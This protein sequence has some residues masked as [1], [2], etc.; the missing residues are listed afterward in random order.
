M[1]TTTVEKKNEACALSSFRCV[2]KKSNFVSGPELLK[3]NFN[4][5]QDL[6][7]FPPH[8]LGEDSSHRS[9]QISN[10]GDPY[11]PSRDSYLRPQSE[12]D[13]NYL[14]PEPPPS[15]SPFLDIFRN[16]PDR[17]RRPSNAGFFRRA[18][19]VNLRRP[20][21]VV[22]H[23]L[24]PSTVEQRSELIPD[25]RYYHYQKQQ[26]QQ[27]PPQ[28]SLQQVAA[29]HFS[30][31]YELPPLDL[32]DEPTRK[33]AAIDLTELSQIYGIPL[34]PPRMEDEEGTPYLPQRR[35]TMPTVLDPNFLPEP[36][37]MVYKT[38]FN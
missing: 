21:V 23:K 18:S 22:E 5:S 29:D 28:L 24:V 37:G 15:Q 38:Y 12:F 26:Q 6:S 19:A 36:E 34:T 1:R 14:S 4:S 30:Q 35:S 2:I 7:D 8:L 16:N 27:R 31:Y 20:S 32:K 9:F 17:D 11:G 3:R 25:Q 10:P 33:K 13:D